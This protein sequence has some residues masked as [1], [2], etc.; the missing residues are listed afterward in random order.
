[1]NMNFKRKGFT[2]V[3]LMVVMS[4]LALLMT[5]MTVSVTRARR[6][7]QI[8]KA[9]TDVG[10]V[11]QAILA[12][13][14]YTK[15]GLPT[16]NDAEVD[17]GNLGFLF[18]EGGDAEFDGKNVVLLQSGLTN[19]RMLDPWGTPYRVKITKG[20]INVPSP[21]RQLETGYMLPNIDRLTKEER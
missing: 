3:E 20:T 21:M 1:M 15:D 9:Q 12:Y 5:A 16:L 18:G 11:S 6:T 13:E 7:A 4:I 2:L 14:N 10:V 8:R 19:G 17:T